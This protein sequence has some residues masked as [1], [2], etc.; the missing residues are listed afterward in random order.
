MD[1]NP[2][3]KIYCLKRYKL[4]IFLILQIV[5]VRIL[6][7]FPEFIEKFYSNGFYK[8]LSE[9]SRKLF[10]AIGFSVGDVLYGLVIVFL[11]I[12]IIK[13][14]KQWNFKFFVFGILNVVSVFYFL[15]NLLWG[16]NYYRIPLTEKMNLSYEYSYRQ[17]LDYTAKLIEKSN[18]LHLEITRNDSAKVINPY[19]NQ[20]I[21][22]K[23]QNG[24]DKLVLNYP[25]FAY[26]KHCVKNSLISLPL[27]YM[28]C[29]GYL[30]PFTG[31][32]QVNALLPK[33]TFPT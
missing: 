5:T 24:Y 21:F 23:S 17:L 27:S 26:N 13:K 19:T 4:I 8:L 18:T 25:E 31:E 20:Q 33:Y 16:L 30:N 9:G 22:E 7:F 1:F 3:G 32:A 2:S 15:F 29:G 11:I 10:S 6:A 28:G 14:R 12:R